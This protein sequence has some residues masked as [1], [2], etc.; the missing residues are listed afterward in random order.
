MG[1]AP[2][3]TGVSL[4]GDPPLQG[5][6]HPSPIAHPRSVLNHM[7]QIGWRRHHANQQRP[8]P[9]LEDALWPACQYMS[10]SLRYRA[11]VHQAGSG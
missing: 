1:S 7:S 10:S 4:W 2:G 5:Q 11:C 9:M 6:S 3:L 8:L